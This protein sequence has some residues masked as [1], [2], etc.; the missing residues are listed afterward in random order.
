MVILYLQSSYA[1][2][3]RPAD[4]NTLNSHFKIWIG[5]IS[6][7]PGRI[8]CSLLILYLY[9]SVGKIGSH[10]RIIVDKSKPMPVERWHLLENDISLVGWAETP[11]KTYYKKGYLIQISLH[12]GISDIPQFCPS[13]CHWCPNDYIIHRD[14]CRWL[15]IIAMKNLLQHKILYQNTAQYG[16]CNLTDAVINGEH[17]PNCELFFKMRV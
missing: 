17:P 8:L 7:T 16:Q 4:S 11:G 10:S 9:G 2:H 5:R 1:S 3:M 15:F 6:L 13:L 12:W 14:S